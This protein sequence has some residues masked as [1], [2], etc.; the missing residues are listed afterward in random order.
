MQVL[1][2]EDDPAF[3]AQIAQ[4]MM[5][6]G[7][8][9]LCV[10]T[11]PAAEAFLR[12]GMVD[13]LIAGER[14][15]GKLSHPVALLA[16]CRNPLLAAVLR[17]D[18]TGPDVDE[19]F[20]LVP[21]L[22]GIMGRAVAPA[23]VSQIVLAATTGARTE[24]V[25]TRLAARWA[26]ADQLADQL[27][28]LAPAAFADA[29]PS[30]PARTRDTGD[31]ATMAGAGRSAAAPAARTWDG[32]W[33]AALADADPALTAAPAA[34][35][36]DA[37]LPTTPA[38]EP[39]ARVAASPAGQIAPPPA[40]AALPAHSPRPSP[41]SP[42]ARVMAAGSRAFAR[43][44]QTRPPAEAVPAPAA[45]NP[46]LPAWFTGATLP[47]AEAA[48]PALPAPAQPPARPLPALIPDRR[49]HLN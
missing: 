5:G 21:S 44:H 19:L 38:D 12:L 16:E 11:V 43:P 1:I 9:V 25:P 18:R 42:L 45:R 15:G 23:L 33:P 22:V 27:A 35:I 14:I 30:D 41:D 29:A 20:D 2:L 28:D 3:Q 13:V 31:D 4:T 47:R 40:G 48:T 24:T 34:A 7:F 49:L 26:A 6:H 39:A 36:A 17:T 46:A 32:L 37:A 8:N 10:E